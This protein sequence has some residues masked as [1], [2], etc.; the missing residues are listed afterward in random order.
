DPEDRQAALT[1]RR[2]LKM[3]RSAHAFVRGSTA[4]FYEWLDSAAGSSLPKGPAVW[5]CGDCHVGNLGPIASSKGRIDIQVRDLDQTVIGNPAHDLIRIGLSLASAARGSDLPGVTTARMMEELIDGYALA[6][7]ARDTGSADDSEIERPRAVRSALTNAINRKWKHLAQ[8]RLEADA[9]RLP[10]GR[11]FWPLTED[12]RAGLEA[13]FS[14]EKVRRMVTALR[15][16]D[17]DA[18]VEIRDAAYWVKGCSSLGRLRYAVLVAIGGG[19]G[20]AR[21][22]NT[23]YCLIDVKEAAKALAPRYPDVDMP[24]DNAERVVAGAWHISPALGER[25]VAARIGDTPV[26]LRELL[27]QDLK[28]EIEHL[29][30]DEAMRVARYLG[31]VTGQAHARQCDEATRTEWAA[32]L[33]RGRSKS[34]DAPSWLWA[35]VVELMSSHEG[36]YL[37]HCRRY[38]MQTMSLA[39]E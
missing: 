21:N 10:L 3:A 5:I 6:F 15:G 36:A 17:D 14:S 18:R 28:L 8:E 25:M 31:H 35:A 22:D 7:R 11:R 16:R 39:A 2:N 27:P 24:R 1:Q 33:A 38:A 37:D 26:F 30:P 13:L 23:E 9:P 12:E 19:R 4:K 20:E 29:T 32:T 34:L